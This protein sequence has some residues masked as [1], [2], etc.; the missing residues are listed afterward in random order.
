VK[1]KR[2]KV[3]LVVQGQHM[4]KDKVDFTDAFSPVPH[5]SGV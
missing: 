4:S 3:S 1:V 2:L 5:L